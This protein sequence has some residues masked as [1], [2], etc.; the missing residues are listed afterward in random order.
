[1]CSTEW[2]LP[3]S[4]VVNMTFSFPHFASSFQD[5]TLVCMLVFEGLIICLLS[6]GGE[7]EELTAPPILHLRERTFQ[8]PITAYILWIS[9][10]AYL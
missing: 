1:M 6:I 2:K 9:Y 4:S 7:R 8:W 5:A 3:K 10:L